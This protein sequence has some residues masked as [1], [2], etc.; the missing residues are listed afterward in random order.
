MTDVSAGRSTPRRKSR[1][2]QA[3][4]SAEV[5]RLIGVQRAAGP[6]PHASATQISDAERWHEGSFDR[7]VTESTRGEKVR[8]LPQ[9][10]LAE[11][12][13]GAGRTG[14]SGPSAA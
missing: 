11:S 13:P 12:R 8:E 7:A 3:V 1:H 14:R 4:L 5:R 10:F 9:D 2:D 6:C